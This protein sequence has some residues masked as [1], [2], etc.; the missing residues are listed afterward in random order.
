MGQQQGQEIVMVI[1]DFKLLGS[2]QQYTAYR[3]A[4]Y[5]QAS[6]Q[7][8]NAKLVKALEKLTDPNICFN[9]SEAQIPF[10]SHGEAIKAFVEARAALALAKEG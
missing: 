2:L 3:D 4:A 9:G 1:S 5:A 7:A 6:L 8:K 10:S